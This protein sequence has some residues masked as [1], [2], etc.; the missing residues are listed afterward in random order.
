LFYFVIV[1]PLFSFLSAPG[2]QREIKDKIP[3]NTAVLH[4]NQAELFVGYQD[5]TV[6]VFDLSM[7]N[8]PVKEA[9]P[10]D[11]TAI[12]SLSVSPDGSLLCAV[13]NSVLTFH[14]TFIVNFYIQITKMACLIIRY[15]GK[16]FHLESSIT[17]LSQRSH[18]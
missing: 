17:T 9:I 7:T 8:K 15:E 14:S 16:L 4:P 11:D 5:G 3:I 6:K 13:N 10:E 18:K 2:C 12:R 1:I